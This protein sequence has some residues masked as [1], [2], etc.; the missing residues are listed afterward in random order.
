[1]F[2]PKN[3]GKARDR[4]HLGFPK[5]GYESK[6]FIHGLTLSPGYS[7]L[8]NSQCV[9]HVSGILCKL[10]LDNHTKKRQSLNGQLVEILVRYPYSQFQVVNRPRD[11]IR[12]NP[13]V[14]GREDLLTV[15]V[16]R[17]SVGQFRRDSHYISVL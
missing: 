5:A 12:R 14:V 11:H 2:I 7:R 10:S 16:V 4:H 15:A 9:N 13:H 1:M 3:E 6:S 17:P 8:S